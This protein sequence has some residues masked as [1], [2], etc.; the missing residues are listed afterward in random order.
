MDLIAWVNFETVLTGVIEGCGSVGMGGGGGKFSASDNED[1][2]DDEEVPTLPLRALF[3]P[4]MG[5][6]GS[7]GGFSPEGHISL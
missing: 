2:G 1:V 5:L 3:E 4:G 6:V 7:G